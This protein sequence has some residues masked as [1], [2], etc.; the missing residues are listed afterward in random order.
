MN[1]LAEV[2]LEVSMKSDRFF[3]IFSKVFNLVTKFLQS[4]CFYNIQFDSSV[5]EVTTCSEGHAEEQLLMCNTLLQVL[6]FNS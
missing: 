5:A 1:M 2:Q 6:C 3:S 4:P